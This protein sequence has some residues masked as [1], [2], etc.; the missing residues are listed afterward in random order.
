MAS[1][2]F[3]AVDYLMMKTFLVY[4]FH[5]NSLSEWVPLQC[6]GFYVKQHCNVQQHCSAI[7]FFCA[8]VSRAL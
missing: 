4:T 7:L 8:L 5:V 1:Q 6:H 3:I 2:K